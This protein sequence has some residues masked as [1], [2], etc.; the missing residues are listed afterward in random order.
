MVHCGKEDFVIG[1]VLYTLIHPEHKLDPNDKP[2]LCPNTNFFLDGGYDDLYKEV[3][4]GGSVKGHLGPNGE[5][6]ND[7]DSSTEAWQEVCCDYETVKSA[8]IEEFKRRYKSCFD[9]LNT[10]RNKRMLGHKASPMIPRLEQL[11][12][13]AHIDLPKY[14]ILDIPIES[15]IAERRRRR[16]ERKAALSNQ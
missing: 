11:A 16:L 7:N 5:F 9:T 10:P 6:I 4:F 8:A 15:P 13:A 1:F 12:S 2:N 3:L 14:E